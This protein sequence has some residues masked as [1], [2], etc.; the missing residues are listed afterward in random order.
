MCSESNLRSR[1]RVR[2]SQQ[3]PDLLNPL[4][5]SLPHSLTHSVPCSAHP[6]LLFLLCPCLLSISLSADGTDVRS[7][8]KSNGELTLEERE[9]MLQCLQQLSLQ[10]LSL[11]EPES[12]HRQQGEH[13][14]KGGGG[15]GGGGKGGKGEP[16]RGGL[17][18]SGDSGG[19]GGDVDFVNRSSPI[20]DEKRRER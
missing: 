6:A 4:P 15:G 10:Q 20:E 18:S 19:E 14:G 2:A 17:S 1:M 16:N 3:L 8:L 13:E 12:I 11:Q 9:A 7:A 5:P